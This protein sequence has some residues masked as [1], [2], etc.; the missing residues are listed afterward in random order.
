V[1]VE[2]RDQDALQAGFEL[3]KAPMPH[4][5]E[6]KK[7]K[8][9]SR[10]K[11]VAQQIRNFKDSKDPEERDKLALLRWERSATGRKAEKERKQ[12]RTQQL[13]EPKTE[14]TES[15]TE[16][17][18]ES[19][20]EPKTEPTELVEPKTEPTES[21][22]E[23]KT[24]P[25]TEP[26]ELVEPKTEPTEST[27][28]S[29]TE[30]KAEQDA[31]SESSDS[32][33]FPGSPVSE[34]A[35]GSA[36]G[37]WAPDSD[38]DTSSSWPDTDTEGLF[39]A[40]FQT[41]SGDCGSKSEVEVKAEVDFIEVKAEEVEVKAEVCAEAFR[42]LLAEAQSAEYF[43][44]SLLKVAEKVG[45]KVAGNI[46]EARRMLLNRLAEVEAEAEAEEAGPAASIEAASPS[47]KMRRNGSSVLAAHEAC[48]PCP[49]PKTPLA[50][51]R[52][53]DDIDI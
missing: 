18:T 20:T 7:K 33:M 43:D 28:E 46:A 21:T 48:R 37:A 27:T 49:V 40:W 29:K 44:A 36:P 23:S 50:R 3:N 6:K 14:P 11:R 4:P 17:T 1:E 2:R 34:V 53:N 32:P 35:S 38:T 52:L 22:T 12:N 10:G 42:G 16:S 30:T 26:T 51:F 25:K 5:K 8:R 41:A 9:K 47:S 19:K 15:K 31:T 45:E 39:S 24:E 13:V